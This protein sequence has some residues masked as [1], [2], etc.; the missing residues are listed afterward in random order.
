MFQL[1]WLSKKTHQLCAT[2]SRTKGLHI[3]LFVNLF[4]MKVSDWKRLHRPINPVTENETV[5]IE[6]FNNKHVL[7]LGLMH[8]YS[9]MAKHI[10]YFNLNIYIINY[11]GWV[12]ESVSNGSEVDV[13]KET[14]KNGMDWKR[15]KLIGCDH[16]TTLTY[17]QSPLQIHK[18]DN[19]W[20]KVAVDN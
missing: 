11:S 6:P 1:E 3:H 13:E 12:C 16:P 20:F 10:L 5:A 19:C 2:A 15:L 8:C 4:H 17:R 14:F 7:A 9:W 18:F